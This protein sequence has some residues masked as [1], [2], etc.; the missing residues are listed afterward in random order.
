MFRDRAQ[1]VLELGPSN[2][3]AI[4]FLAAAERAI[5]GHTPDASLHWESSR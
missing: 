2:G 1:N 5:G 4:N 3:D